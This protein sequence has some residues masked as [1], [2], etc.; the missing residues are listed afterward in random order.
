M[1]KNGGFY[2]DKIF[3]AGW[4]YIIKLLTRLRYLILSFFFVKIE[5][6]YNRWL[7]TSYHQKADEYI[8]WMKHN[9]LFMKCIFFLPFRPSRRPCRSANRFPPSQTRIRHAEGRPRFRWFG[10]D[11]L[12]EV[13]LGL[14]PRSIGWRPAGKM[15]I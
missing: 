4:V 3:Y 15:I 11:C 9:I 12:K 6:F 13:T 10:L 7:T 8:F 2:F 1:D 14:P 5:L